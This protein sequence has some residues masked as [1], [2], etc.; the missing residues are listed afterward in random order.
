M[1]VGPVPAFPCV[2]GPL[3]YTCSQRSNSPGSPWS[4]YGQI[5]LTTDS[6]ETQP[7]STPT[8]ADWV[9]PGKSM[10]SATD[11]DGSA[12]DASPDNPAIGDT[13]GTGTAVALGCIGG[14]IFLIVIALV[15]L[16]VSRLLS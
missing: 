5:P 14:T 4:L 9:F 13:V 1:C 16:L 8:L 15:I 3:P 6:S 10:P 7:T 2:A 11:G 12:Q